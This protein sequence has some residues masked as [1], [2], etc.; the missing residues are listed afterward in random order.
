MS[1]ILCATR[2]G[3]AS[4]RTQDAVIARAKGEGAEVLFLYVV[5][6]EFLKQTFTGARADVML[7]EM[8]RMGNF[9]L[10][11]A[12]ERA[13]KAGVQ[14]R[15]VLRH[16]SLV[17]ALREVAGEEEVTLIAF[18]RPAKES[19]FQP[20]GLEKLTQKLKEETGILTEII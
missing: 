20:S 16:G 19:V 17:E 11:M 3:E 4:Y 5:D 1:K 14:A 7:H 18:G 6:L 10:A 9:L 15:P 12:C 13:E 2:G 8:E